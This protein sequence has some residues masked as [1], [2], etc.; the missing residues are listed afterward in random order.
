MKE[1]V[2]RLDR[3][4]LLLG[5]AGAG[6]LGAF[7]AA[8]R[9]VAADKLVVGFI[10]VGPQDDYGYNQAH[11]AGRRG[12]KKLPGVKVVEEEKVPETVDVQKT[13]ERMIELDGAT[14]LFPTSFGYFD[15]HI[16]KVAEKYPEGHASST[17]A[18]SGPRASTRRTSAATS[19]TSTSASTW[20]ASSPAT[21]SKTKKLGFIAAK[22][23]PQVLRN[24]NAFTLGARSVDPKVTTQRRLHRRLVAAGQGGR[25]RQQPDRPGR[26]RPHLPRRQ[27]EGHRRDG[28]APR[29]LR[30]RLP[31]QPGARWRP[32]ATSPA[33]SGTGR[34]RTRT[35]S[36][37]PMAGKPLPNLLRGGL[38]EGFVKIVAL[39][40]GGV[41]RRP[42]RTPTP[43]RR[44]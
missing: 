9:A 14:L 3:R 22:P 4:E 33:P 43:S 41:R 39:R 40:Q 7:A 11:A 36:R 37:T 29:H 20:P 13:M 32:R 27:P 19:A 31:R 5:L 25:G 15:P 30:L 18:G 8:S 10:Y 6:A 21:T 23:I 44:R 2:G 16:L 28:R 26:R 42:R 17:A 1:L 35:T 12:V 38:K 34:R 24:I